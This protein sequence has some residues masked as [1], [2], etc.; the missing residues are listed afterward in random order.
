MKSNTYNNM[1]TIS[2]LIIISLFFNGVFGDPDEVKSVSVMEG[3]SVTLHT[4]L[5]DIQR[6]EQID[7]WFKGDR[8][9]QINKATSNISVY[10][11]DADGRFRDRLQVDD[12]TGSL[13]I[14]NMRSENSG[15]YKVDIISITRHT[16][17][18]SF[19]VTVRGGVK[20][21]MSVME[22]HSVSLYT[23]TKMTYDLIDWMFG[24]EHAQIAEIYK[25]DKRFTTY[26]DVLDGRFRNRLKLND[27]SGSLT[28]ISMRSEHAGVYEVK[29]SSN[30]HSVHRRFKVT[31]TVLGLRLVYV[32]G[33]CFFL[34]FLAAGVTA[35]VI[36]C[37]CMYHRR[38]FISGQEMTVMKGDS[39]TLRTDHL[40]DIQR[41][42]M[43]QWMYEDAE[44]ATIN[45]ATIS[46]V[47]PR[48]RNGLQVNEQTGSLT[49]TNITSDDSGVYRLNIFRYRKFF[50]IKNVKL[51]KIIRIR[52]RSS[53]TFNMIV[54][55]ELIQVNVG[56]SV[57]LET[58]VTE[59]QNNEMIEWRFRDEDT[60]IAEISLA[61]SIPC[62]DDNDDLFKNMELNDQTGDLTINKIKHEHSGVYTLKINGGRN[63]LR[64][65]CVMVTAPP[66]NERRESV[67]IHVPL[68][69]ETSL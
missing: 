26:D 23:D 24:D 35:F 12:Q 66:A 29:M 61:H 30:R 6:D 21:K 36:Y 20:M 68:V 5:T 37:R 19:R 43:I 39:I 1:K 11:D 13:T 54:I 32:V 8:I 33:I 15:L 42:D 28:I 65:L 34:L 57:T 47:A 10:D 58:G 2:L 45:N 48:F 62:D 22:G 18:Q 53:K 51:L 67:E 3:D 52:K 38:L 60:P 56:E 31:V 14:T 49:I 7:W 69:K 9:A 25:P 16:T 59:I 41:D 55:D 40:T 17:H 46:F 27:Q 50:N 64:R 4:D 44:I 63:S